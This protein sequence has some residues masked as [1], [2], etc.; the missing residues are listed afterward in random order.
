[1]ELALVLDSSNSI[2]HERLRVMKT[3]CQHVVSTLTIGPDQTRV[4]VTLFGQKIYNDSFGLDNFTTEAEV[5]EAIGR[6]EHRGGWYTGTY[7]GLIHLRETQ[8][9]AQVVRP[10]VPKVAVV[11]T[12]GNSQ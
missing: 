8:M 6:I 9:S 5:N 3:F 1:M 10:D 11:L 2:S 7:E 12:D 4:A